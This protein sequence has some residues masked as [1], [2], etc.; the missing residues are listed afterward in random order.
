[1]KALITGGAGF[2]GSH[3]AQYLLEKGDSVVVVDNLSTGKFDNIRRFAENRRF[4][5]HINTILNEQLME[6]LIEGCDVIFHLAAAVGVRLIIEHPVETI[7][8]NIIGTGTVLKYANRYK[9]KTLIASTSE[10]YGK[11]NNVPFKEEDD[12]VLG[13]T[14]KSRWSYACSKAIDEFLA[15]AYYREKKLPVIIARLFNTIGPRQTGKYGMV[16]PTFVQQAL[17]NHPISVFDDGQQSR[18]FTNVSDV[19]GALYLLMSEPKAVGEVFNIGTDEEITILELAK[20]VKE[21]TGSESEIQFISYEKAFE[22]GFE[23]MRRRVPDISKI[24]DLIGYEPKVD[25]RKSIQQII[26]Y[27]KA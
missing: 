27:F 18:C 1:M 2:I 5:I 10:I 8:T 9:V 26:N 22:S 15:L 11:S 19:V 16:V 20:L 23:D 7:E 21:L 6:R 17:L 24:S 25:L 3:L 13:A 12:S 14:I 4:Q